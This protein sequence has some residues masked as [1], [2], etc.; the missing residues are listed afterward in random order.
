[1][2]HFRP[3]LQR[4]FDHPLSRE[5]IHQWVDRLVGTDNVFVAFDSTACSSRRR[6]APSPSEPPTSP[7]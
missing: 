1:M 7:C 6:C 2:T 5:E 3:R 4:R